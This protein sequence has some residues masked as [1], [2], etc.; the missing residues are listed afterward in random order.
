MRPLT[1]TMSAFGPYAGRTTLELSK[2]GRGGLYLITGDTG[3]GKTTIFDAI[4]FAL[5][6]EASGD[7]R[8]AGMFR[9]KYAAPETPTEVELLF[10]YAGKQYRIRR[11]PEYDRPKTRGE[12]ITTEKANAELFYPDGRVVTKQREVNRAIEELLGI[13]RNQFTQI[14]MIAQG[15]FQKLL[16]ASTEDRKKIFQKIFHTKNYNKLQELLKAEERTLFKDAEW[17]GNTI[18][19]YTGGILCGEDAPLSVLVEK[20]KAGDLPTEEVV[21]LLGKLEASDTEAQQ[22]LQALADEKAE[23]I[24]AHTKKLALAEDRKRTEASLLSSRTRLAQLEPQSEALNAALMAAEARRPEIVACTEQ[25]T[26]LNA[27]LPDF[28][29]LDQKQQALEQRV[30]D[31]AA[32]TRAISE[33]RRRAEL[34]KA[35]L[36]QQKQERAALSTALEEKHALDVQRASAEQLREALQ[37]YA[38]AASDLNDLQTE[39][40][41][42][43]ADYLA[44]TADAQEKRQRYDRQYKAYLDEQAGVLAQTLAEGLPCPVCGSLTH[45]HPAFLSAAAPSKETLDNSKQAQEAA[46]RL[47]ASA[48]EQANAVRGTIAAREAALKKQ[49]EKLFPGVPFAQTTALLADKA[50]ACAAQLEELTLQAEAAGRRVERKQALDKLIPEKESALEAEMSALATLERTLAEQTAGEKALA[51]QV[52]A[53]RKTL[54]FSSKE[55]AA[56]KITALQSQRDAMETAISQAREACTA[57]DKQMIGLKAAIDEAK[58]AI[59]GS[60]DLDAA[61]ESELLQAL[62]REKRALDE[63]LQVVSTRLTTN[64]TVL[65]NILKTA[66]EAAATEARL[67]WVRA[68]SDTANGTISGKEKIMLETYIQMTYF[69]RIIRR[70][71]TRLMVMSGGQY[72]LKRKTDADNRQ[73]QSGLELDVI[74]HS[75]GSERSVKTLSGGESF[76]ASLSLALGLSDEIQSSAGGIQLD[77]MFVD[78]GFGSLD[79]ESLQQAMRA[80]SSLSEGNRLVGIISHVAE[81]K[82][83]IDR[84]LVVKK[85]KTGGSTVAIIV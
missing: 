55:E 50:E 31:I 9:S 20:A 34:E 74:D 84:Q 7:S 26:T 4:T 51:E 66:D 25:I 40:K 57:C 52:E 53:L 36:A 8:E 63:G 58:K 80:L 61:H 70:A 21:T 67:R 46:D 28:E 72:E 78:E 62:N 35:A 82:E 23:A 85:E 17:A 22:K 2:F 59:R 71:N 14:A 37:D 64:R 33:R 24:A 69:D 68:L 15:D 30:H 39:L 29:V 54:P 48:S 49:A 77:T 1:L 32:A 13:D 3:A 6:G 10:E 65:T 12:G 76:K 79:E 81:L 11:N 75:N 16:L 38:Q 19:Q 83:K 18:R 43:Q 42:L 44:K 41:Q 47:A 73:S 56:G 5:F 60:E 45:P 27:K